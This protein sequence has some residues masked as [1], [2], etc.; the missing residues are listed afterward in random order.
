MPIILIY[1]L[2]GIGPGASYNYIKS[3]ILIKYSLNSPEII[4]IFI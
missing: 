2:P 1:L 4:F 3:P